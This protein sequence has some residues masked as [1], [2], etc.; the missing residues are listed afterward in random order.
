[1]A[2]LK[3][4]LEAKLLQIFTN[5]FDYPLAARELAGAYADYS[6]TALAA[7]SAPTFIGTERNLLAQTLLAAIV[8]PTTGTPAKMA[9][10][11][12]DGVRT[13]WLTPPVAFAGAAGIGPAT[14]FV[15]EPLLLS[16]LTTLFSNI[17]NTTQTA[18]RQL[19][20]YLDAATK[21]I[22]TTLVLGPVTTTPFLT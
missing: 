17:S 7:A 10:A 9:Q 6:Q 15:G 22:Q 11:W 18:A 2:L 14:A 12:T 20:E 16:L 3:A 19:A 4:T 1:M 5:Q 8:N 21:T 13:F